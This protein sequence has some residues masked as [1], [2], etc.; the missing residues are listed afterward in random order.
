MSNGCIPLGSH[1]FT[2]LYIEG[3]NHLVKIPLEDLQLSSHAASRVVDEEME[4]RKLLSGDPEVMRRGLPSLNS[5]ISSVP[6]LWEPNS[7][8]SNIHGRAATTRLE[9]A[10]YRKGFGKVS[11]AEKST[12]FCAYC[13]VE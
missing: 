2:S 1:W 9:R 12:S 13:L 11:A 8:T 3:R 4:R 7:N 10:V 6:S 5:G